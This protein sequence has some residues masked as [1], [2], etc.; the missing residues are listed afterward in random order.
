MLTPNH[1]LAALMGVFGMLAV[2][3][4]VFAFR[5]V[6]NDHQWQRVER[7]VRVSFWGMNIGLALMV[8]TNL[9]PGGLLQLADAINNGY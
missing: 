3:L 9:F 2:A 6:L 4:M 8:V 1:D 5:Q 7:Y